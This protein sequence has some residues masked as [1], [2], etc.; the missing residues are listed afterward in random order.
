MPL[1]LAFRRPRQDCW[2]PLEASLDYLSEF[3][4]SMCYIEKPCL[5]NENKQTQKTMH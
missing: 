4:A 2:R 1:I 3:K 5:K